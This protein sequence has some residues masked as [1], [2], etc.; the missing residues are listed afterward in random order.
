MP[1]VNYLRYLFGVNLLRALQRIF[2]SFS[3]EKERGEYRCGE[4][5]MLFG[6]KRSLEEHETKA[7]PRAEK[8][9]YEEKA[10]G[11]E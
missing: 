11:L 7:H 3:M 4:C 5:G 8:Q 6:D 1:D 2:L 9:E 10:K